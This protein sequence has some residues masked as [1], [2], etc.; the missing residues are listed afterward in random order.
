MAACK[1]GGTGQRVTLALS[2]RSQ[3]GPRHHVG[4]PPLD[5]KALALEVDTMGLPWWHSD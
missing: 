2:P 5:S 4:E 1:I 3:A